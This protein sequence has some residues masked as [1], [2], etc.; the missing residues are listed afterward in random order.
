MKKREHLPSIWRVW[1][2]DVWGNSKDGYEVNDR[3]E[4]RHRITLFNAD[5]DPIIIRDLINNGVL[6]KAAIDKVVIEGDDTTLYVAEKKGDKP[7]LQLER[8]ER[9]NPLNKAERRKISHVA[10]EH[11]RDARQHRSKDL[12]MFDGGTAAGLRE[13]L[14]M[15][16]HKNPASGMPSDFSAKNYTLVSQ[17]TAK[18]PAY[19]DASNPDQF[20]RK[21]NGATL[22]R[23][24]TR[25]EK[26]P[27][28]RW[29]R[30]EFKSRY[31]KEA[32]Y[33]VERTNNNPEHG[34]RSNVG[35]YNKVL[36]ILEQYRYDRTAEYQLGIVKGMNPKKLSQSDEDTLKDLWEQHN[37]NGNP[38]AGPRRKTTIHQLLQL[39]YSLKLEGKG[40]KNSRGSVIKF[41]RNLFG[42][43]NLGVSR[44]DLIEQCQALIDAAHAA[45]AGLTTPFEINIEG[46][47]YDNPLNVREQAAIIKEARLDL[48]FATSVKKMGKTNYANQLRGEAI[49]KF[50]TAA[51]YGGQG[52]NSQP[53]DKMLATWSRFMSSARPKERYDSQGHR[54]NP[55]EYFG[56]PAS[57]IN[58]A[59]GVA[60]FLR[61]EVE[62]ANGRWN[63]SYTTAS[64]YWVIHKGN[65]HH[66][67]TLNKSEAN[68]ERGIGIRRNPLEP[69][70]PLSAAQRKSITDYLKGM[71]LTQLK[72]QLANVSKNAAEF[73]LAQ[74]VEIDCIIQDAI[75][76]LSTPHKNPRSSVPSGKGGAAPKGAVL[77][78]ERVKQVEYYD[79]NK[80]KAEGLRNPNLPWR[81][82]YKEKSAKVFGLPD[83]SVLIKG[84]K[85]LWGYR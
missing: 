9:E 24:V 51:R 16:A 78:G 54:I 40:M 12:Q 81:H 75:K 13:A 10:A 4:L 58:T 22:I 47:T 80:A 56:G 79:V 28:A 2:L 30:L 11:A 32:G 35:L 69:L 29:N 39:K 42:V 21:S 14:A 83:G 77:I 41:V 84:K 57:S 67:Y 65:K 18:L 82:D 43:D 25:Y 73:N 68:K 26:G 37:A 17:T 7:L 63:D 31:Y 5:S 74:R 45:G 59:N 70:V 52:M 19:L 71:N 60:Y 61:T 48:K 36:K 38:H 27:D 44:A 66:V 34:L 8:E 20:E 62:N 1:A 3:S 15:T 53:S 23:W 55:L 33:T 76:S 46:L 6:T 72:T 50:N 85:K 49:G 64:G